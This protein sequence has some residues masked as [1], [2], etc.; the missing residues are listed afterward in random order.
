MSL[1]VPCL[2]LR[3]GSDDVGEDNVFMYVVVFY[4]SKG[5][6]LTIQQLF[7]SMKLSKEI[8]KWLLLTYKPEF[9][10]SGKE[11]RRQFKFNFMFLF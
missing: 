3:L 6:I 1:T 8:S 4:E 10:C 2:P 5:G 11:D 7:K 9:L